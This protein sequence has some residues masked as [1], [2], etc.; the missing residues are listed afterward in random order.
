MGAHFKTAVWC[1]DP[2][3]VDEPGY[4]AVNKDDGQ[5]DVKTKLV[6]IDD[7]PENAEDPAGHFERA[8]S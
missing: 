1:S 4:Y 6:W 2:E 8:P 5:I 7:A 3:I